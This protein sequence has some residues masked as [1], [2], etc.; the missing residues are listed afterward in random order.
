MSKSVGVSGFFRLVGEFHKDRYK[1]LYWL[2]AANLVIMLVLYFAQFS[3]NKHTKEAQMQLRDAQVSILAA[4]AA[5]CRHDNKQAEAQIANEKFKLAA[6]KA[7]SPT[8]SLAEQQ[9]QIRQS[10]LFLQAYQL[11]DCKIYDKIIIPK[12]LGVSDDG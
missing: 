10:E 6:L 12:D 8:G 5:T 11:K 4:Q 9:R 2:V 1:F 3:N 7:T